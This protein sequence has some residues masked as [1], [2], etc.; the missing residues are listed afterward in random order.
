MW[1][2]RNMWAIGGLREIGFKPNSDLLM[3]LS[4]QGR[5]VFDCIK[6][7][8]IARDHFDY[9]AEKWDSDLGIV[10]GIGILKNENIKCGGFEAPDIL[11][12]ET[13]DHWIIEIKSEI[14]PNWQQKELKADVMYLQNRKTKESIEIAVFHYGIDRSYGFSDTGNSF[15]VGTAS[16]ITIW[17]RK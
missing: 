11:K 15:V 17:N 8:K 10:E 3:V 4:S 2:K 14:R 5:G 6:D 7:E 16:D 9:Y 12:K 1:E 13:E